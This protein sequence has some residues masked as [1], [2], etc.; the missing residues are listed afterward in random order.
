MSPKSFID[1]PKLRDQADEGAHQAGWA[2]LGPAKAN[3]PAIVP[4]PPAQRRPSRWPRRVLALVVVLVAAGG[5]G[6][7][8]W[9]RSRPLLPPGIVSGNG[10]LEADEVDIA[11]KFAGRILKLYVDEGDMVKAG[12]VVAVMDTRD[13]QAQLK[14]YQQTVLQ[15]QRLLEQTKETFASQQAVVRLAQQEVA[16]TTYLVPKVS[17]RSELLISKPS[18]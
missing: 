3:L 2:G 17:P 5:I 13:L 16:R 8:S 4:A 11:T 1:D 7:W 9:L 12:Q 10:R 18:S 14:Q 6:Y 15:G